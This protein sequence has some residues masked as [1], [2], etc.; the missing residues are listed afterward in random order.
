MT[1]ADLTRERLVRA[2]L[3]LFTAHGYHET[4]TP[5]IAKKAGVA[6][7]T[8]YRHFTSKQHCFN[9]LY[10]TAARWAGQLVKDADA[11]KVG[12]REKLAE[13][14][15]GLVT[16]AAHEA[17]VARLFFIQSHEDLLD[18]ESRKT[19]RDFRLG[20]ESLIAQ[21]KADGSVK[22]GAAEVWAGVWLGVVTV[23][24]DRVST[25]EWPETH[26]GV[27]LALDGA[28]DAIAATTSPPPELEQLDLGRRE[29]PDWHAHHADPAAH[30]QL[31]VPSLKVPHHVLGDQTSRRPPDQGHV[32][33]AAVDVARQ[34]ERD[35]ARGGRIP[36]SGTMGQQHV[37]RVRRRG[38]QGRVHIGLLRIVRRPVVRV[39]D[40]EQPERCAVALDHMAAVLHEYLARIATA[41][42]DLALAG[43]AVVITEHRDHTERRRE[44]AERAHVGRDVGGGDVDHVSRLHDQIGPEPVHLHHDLL[45]RVLAEVHAGVQI[46][47][48]KQ[49]EAV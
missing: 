19:A 42:D 41:L 40:A 25:K 22:A 38:P 44:L 17:A 3:E 11:L 20:L 21:G 48:V 14:A 31:A 45:H 30:V 32:E 6:E 49:L 43:V 10:R 33:L 29:H 18:E 28:W 15:R 1:Q 39:V 12:P 35:A 5:Q 37:K 2:A 36:R 9:E 13:L 47:E 26:A 34:R 24:I 16:G 27:K 4:T 7:G 46:G 23:V 8:I